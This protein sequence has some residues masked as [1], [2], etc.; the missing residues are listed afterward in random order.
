MRITQEEIVKR[1]NKIDDPLVSVICTVYNHEKYI[2]QCLESLLMQSTDFPFEV[3]VHDDAST[4][5]SAAIIKQY[6]DNYPL[7]IKPIYE[8]E[9]QYS[10]HDGSLTR[11]IFSHLN[12]KYVASCEG[13]DYW[14]DADKL[15]LQI[16]Y[17]ESHPSCSMCVH[18]TSRIMEDGT[19]TGRNIN[20]SKRERDYSVEE[21]IEKNVADLFQT[22]S[23][24]VL[25]DIYISKPQDFS[26]PSIGDYP[27]A[28]WMALHGTVHYFPAVMSAYRQ[29]SNASWTNR[30]LK[31]KDMKLKFCDEAI[32]GI[33]KMDALTDYKYHRYFKRSIH[34]YQY[35]KLSRMKKMLFSIVYPPFTKK[36]MFAIYKKAVWNFRRAF[37]N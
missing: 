27:N 28:I 23:R 15:Q 25:K 30:V 34:N 18:N 16:D 1:W 35:M 8:N 5:E 10:K 4:D 14:T 36:I 7:I 9:N 17:M 19:F 33:Q 11:I 20:I 2:A 21:I 22:S 32:V 24:V 13:D 29:F 31:N 6:E 37:N 26:I 3:I 12:G